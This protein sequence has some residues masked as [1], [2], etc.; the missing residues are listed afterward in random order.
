MVSHN[1]LGFRWE[2]QVDVEV[3]AEAN[4]HGRDC[5]Y[6]NQRWPMTVGEDRHAEDNEQM[7][8]CTEL[9]LQLNVKTM[10]LVLRKTFKSISHI[11]FRP[12]TPI[13][14]SIKFCIDA[15]SIANGVFGRASRSHHPSLFFWNTFPIR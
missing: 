3:E 6:A 11:R 2:G 8:S 1:W 5:G 10:R 15:A 14:S 13:V 4:E 12:P 9:A 7:T